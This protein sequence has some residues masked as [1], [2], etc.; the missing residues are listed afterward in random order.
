MRRRHYFSMGLACGVAAAFLLAGSVLASSSDPV[1]G[2]APLI[3][4]LSDVERARAAELAAA[5]LS[6]LIRSNR[7]AVQEVGV[8]HT[9]AGKKLGA[10]VVVSLP[11]AERFH[12]AWPTIDYDRSEPLPQPYKDDQSEYTA[13]GVT[14][15]LILVDLQRDKV[16]QVEPSGVNTETSEVVGNPRR[17]TQP[18][19]D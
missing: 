1:S 16:V 14:S 12:A 6:T 11:G 3:P 10:V 4:S 5:E 7:F 17:R 13:S 19:G 2:S 9:H 15:F 18:L 8:W